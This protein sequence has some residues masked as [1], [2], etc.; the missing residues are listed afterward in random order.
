[1]GVVNTDLSSFRELSRP[2]SSR[3]VIF[4]ERD[5]TLTDPASS[6]PRDHSTDFFCS[7]SRKTFPLIGKDSRFRG[8]ELRFHDVPRRSKKHPFPSDKEW[9]SKE[10][11]V[12]PG[13]LKIFA[14]LVGSFSQLSEF[15]II[16]D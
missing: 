4:F 3:I 1:M 6:V 15:S 9:R 16:L 13:P 8:H 7:L 10:L 11:L 12:S 14:R 5:V 2:S